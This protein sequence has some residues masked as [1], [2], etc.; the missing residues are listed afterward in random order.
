MPPS[1]KLQVFVSS[2]YTD[3]RAERQAAVEAILTA[4]HIPAGMELFAA[5]DESQMDVIKRWIDQSDVYL[6]ILGGRYG[7]VDP[8]LGKSYI[9]LEYEHAVER[10][11][12]LF[13]T[14]IDFDYIE[15]RVRTMGSVAI[16]T[17]HAGK[18]RDFR[19]MVQ[20][21]LVRFWRDPRDIKLAI[22]ETLPEFASRPH[23]SGWV[24]ADDAVNLGPVVEEVSRLSRENADLRQQLLTLNAAQ[25]VDRFNGLT[26]DEILTVLARTS[27]SERDFRAPEL[28]SLRKVAASFEDT[29]L[30]VLHV[31]WRYSARLATVMQM[32]QT[33]G[34]E[35]AKRL[36]EYGLI[37]LV[38]H[39]NSSEHFTLSDAG[40]RFLL[41]LRLER[42][43][44]AA[45][46]Y[47][48]P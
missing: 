27:V 31:L 30:T 46:Q 38:D 25:A 4:G 24:R 48:L 20:S 36:Q 10:G 37:M 18:L 35:S 11:M 42:D 6:L 39:F 34:Y 3:L 47:R 44:A 5:G 16:E 26:L 28:E 9:Q 23:I 2:T 29:S 45:E 8:L 1:K 12:P 14:V 17:E 21:R 40:R 41:R 15:E 33:Q 7:S 22:H 32:G 19:Q 43:L 13:S